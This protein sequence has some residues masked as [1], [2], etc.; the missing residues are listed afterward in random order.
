MSGDED[1]PSKPASGAKTGSNGITRASK[2]GASPELHTE[3]WEDVPEAPSAITD[4]AEACVRFVERALGVRL[5]YSPETLPLLDHYIDAARTAARDKPEPIEVVVES[6]GAYL[7]EVVRRR[8]ASWW[9]LEPDVAGAKLQFHDLFLSFSPMDMIRDAVS[10]PAD[11]STGISFD[12][13]SF[14]L[15]EADREAVRARLAELP[16]V[17]VEEY[18]APSTRV[19]ILDIVIDAVRSRRLSESDPELAL[20]PEDYD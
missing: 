2:P 16:D 13:A 4:L 9:R 19:E 7:G 18:Y 3:K 17:P 15:D 1:N 8:Y 11:V 5:D 20:E 6:A 10:I 14:E 12:L